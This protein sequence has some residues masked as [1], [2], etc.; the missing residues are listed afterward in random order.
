MTVRLRV[1]KKLLSV[2]IA[3]LLLGRITPSIQAQEPLIISDLDLWQSTDASSWESV[4]G[5]YAEGF[6]MAL[7]PAVAFYYLDT[8]TITSSAPLLDGYHEF[9]VTSYP[10]GYFAYWD[11]RGVNASATG[12]Q[13]LMWEIISGSAPIFYLKVSGTDYMLVDGLQYALGQGDQPLR[14]EGSYLLGDYIFSGTLEDTSNETADVDVAIRFVPDLD[15]LES[16]DLA[17]W[18]SIDG[19]FSEGFMM[20]IDPAN[21]YEYLDIEDPTVGFA[22]TDDYH[23]FYVTSHPAGYFD[24]WDSRGVNASATGWQAIMWQIISGNEPIFY[25]KVDGLDYMLVDGLQY[26]LYSEDHP[27]RINGDYLPGLYTF[28]GSIANDYGDVTDLSVDILFND[29]PVAEDQ[30]V[31]TVQDQAVDIT[32]SAVNGYGTL[33]W[34]IVSS[35]LH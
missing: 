11:S 16:V 3:V 34:F 15:L 1:A 10:S 2:L 6:S 32:L 31:E 25:L 30:L 26:A 12:W 20:E 13:A 22:F 35:P 8:N 29:V 23:G 33:E 27:L 19:S 4:P 14:I 21:E 7:D 9:K 28:T 5:S 24:Y 18:T 17:L